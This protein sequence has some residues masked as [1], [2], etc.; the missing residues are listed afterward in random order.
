MNPPGDKRVPATGPSRGARLAWGAFG[1]ALAL[2]VAAELWFGA[3]GRFG[4]D[5]WFGF[6]AWFGL[7]SCVVLVGAAK[8]AGRLLRRPERYYE[9][10]NGNV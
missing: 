8:L 10:R 3:S 4:I 6:G 1:I 5:G 9:D 7:L 2:V